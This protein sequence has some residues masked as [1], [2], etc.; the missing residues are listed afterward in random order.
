MRL[1]EYRV[2]HRREIAGRGIDDLQYFGSGGLL[3]QGLARLVD[4]SRIL[5][6]DDRLRS[7][8]L[9][10]R[11]LPAR[12]RADFG[13]ADRKRADGDAFPD[14]RYPQQASDAGLNSGPRERIAGAVELDL[15]GI[16][17]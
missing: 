1:L 4:Q 15:G 5:H 14:Q 9:Q 3:L 10:Q 2:E 6:R 8:V 17:K 13:S 12:E 11:D 16:G 7:E